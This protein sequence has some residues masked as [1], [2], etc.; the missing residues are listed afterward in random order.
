[1][2]TSHTKPEWAQSKRE[3]ANA[4]RVAQG[5]KPKRRIMPW[6][7]LGLVVVAIVAFVVTR[8][9]PV[10]VVAETTPVE[11][12]KQIRRSETAVVAPSVLSQTVK[13]TGT[14]SPSS[15]TDVAAQVGGRIL[16]LAVQP[17]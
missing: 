2:T 5:L 12:V 7:V 8:P 9:Q 15:Q 16:S 13:V 11:V 10:E 1:M 3:K 17:G 6:V 14:L 4:E